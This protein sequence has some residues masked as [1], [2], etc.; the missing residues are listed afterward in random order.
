MEFWT[1]GAESSQ[2]VRAWLYRDASTILNDANVFLSSSVHAH[3]HTDTQS[4]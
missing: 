2:N 3:T 1:G 4:P